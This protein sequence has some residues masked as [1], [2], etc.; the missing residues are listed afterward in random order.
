MLLHGAPPNRTTPPTQK[1]LRHAARPHHKTKTNGVPRNIL[2]CRSECA[3]LPRLG[4][5]ANRPW[6]A[7][8]GVSWSAWF[9][10]V[11]IPSDAGHF[12]NLG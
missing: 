10:S 4:G 5:V 6:G 7:R 1:P 9:V 8:Q 11:E 3:F 12:R 2:N